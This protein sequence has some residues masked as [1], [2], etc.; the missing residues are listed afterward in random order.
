MTF[1]INKKKHKITYKS[2]KGSSPG[3]IFIHGLNSNMEGLKAKSI[4]KYAKKNKL[5]FIRF[6]LRGH[7]KSEPNFE[8]FSI[9]DWKTDLLYIIDKL[10]KGPQLLIGSSMGGWLMVL[11]A[12]ARPHRICG[13]IGLAAA[14]DFGNT[15]YQSLSIKNKKE[16][17]NNQ[18]IKYHSF[19]FSY[20]LT[21]NFFLDAEKSIIFNK[22]FKFQKPFFLIHGM[23]D[24]VVNYNI[25]KKFMEITSSKNVE[26]T[27]VKNSDHRLSSPFDLLTINSTIDKAILAIKLS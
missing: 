20:L 12:K 21:K 9:S 23:K 4:E 13:L 2:L 27:Y 8:D 3:I 24:D 25:A 22:L 26:I 5:A 14:A 7:G 10:S 19:G 16:L 1:I 17:K 6:D 18:I 11:A 15:I